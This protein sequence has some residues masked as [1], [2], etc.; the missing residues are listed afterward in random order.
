M[1]PRVFLAALLG[2]VVLFVLGFVIYGILLKSWFAS[3]VTG[4]TMHD[5]PIMWALF[6][7]QFLFA[8]L[9]ATVFDRYAT[10]TT[11]AGGAVAGLWMSFLVFLSFDLMTFAFY[12][13]MKL[14]VAFVDAIISAVMGA[15]A[16]AA[17]GFVLG[18]KRK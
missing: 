11:P 18:F 14:Q 4:I 16:G 6:L 13:F 9:L 8:L 10:I 17:I 2:A 7:S 15:I 5:P 1:K 12:P 3:Q